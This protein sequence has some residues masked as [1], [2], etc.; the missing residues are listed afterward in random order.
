M[1]KNT[2]TTVVLL[3][4]LAALAAAPAYGA[5]IGGRVQLDLY[6]Q[7]DTSAEPV[8]AVATGIEAEVLQRQGNLAQIR[9][10]DGTEGWIEARFVTDDPPAAVRLDE[11]AAERDRLRRELEQ[12][13]NAQDTA[14]RLQQ[15]LT[16]AN[17]TINTLRREQENRRQEADEA[18]D[19]TAAEI[20]EQQAQLAALQTR[21][22]ESRAKTASLQSEL[23]VFKTRAAQ[24]R[25]APASRDVLRTILWGLL[26]MLVA[27][28][29]GTVLG[30]RWMAGRVRKR[31]NG[32]KVW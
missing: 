2:K 8:G 20:Q 21:L 3:A 22:S 4:A 15:Q 18:G 32:L 19:A 28:I 29:A 1:T 7:P 6:P 10:E 26:S 13:G 5:W 16:Q 12:A 11:I 25:D 31:F 17:N 27:L 9:L 30:A 14:R 24:R 23:D